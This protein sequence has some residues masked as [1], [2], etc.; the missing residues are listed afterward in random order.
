MDTSV[1]AM[2]S[3]YHVYKDVWD[4]GLGKQLLE[5]QGVSILPSEYRAFLQ[6]RICF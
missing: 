6:I 1:E 2:V 4:A 3:G 5:F